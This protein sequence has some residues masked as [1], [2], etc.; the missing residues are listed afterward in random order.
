M[1][2][3]RMLCNSMVAAALGTSCVIALVLLLNPQL[4]L[5]PARL[6]PLVASVGLFYAV[7]L[8][9]IFYLLLVLRQLFAR[10]IFSPAWISV[11]VLVWLSAVAS[12]AGAA[13]M[14]MNLR[15][16]ALVLDATTRR[17]ARPRRHRADRGG[18]AL[19][20]A[21]D[22]PPQRPR[23]ESDV[24]RA[25]RVRG[26]GLGRGAAGAARARHAGSARR[27]LDRRG[28]RRG[29]QRTVGARHDDRDRRRVARSHHARGR[30]RTPAQLRPDSR[31]RRGAPPR[32]GAADLGRGGVGR[33][34]DRQ[35]A[36]EE[37]RPLGRDLSASPAAAG[38]SAAAR[39]LP[40]ARARA[41]FGFLVEEPHTSATLRTRTLWSILST[42]GFSVGVVGWP[43]TQPAAAVRGYLVSD[44]YHRVAR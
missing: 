17:G 20:A 41:R 21:G 1:R 13:L 5:N 11:S 16:F 31:C 10:E 25:A 40:G 14:W 32:D 23:G 43:L 38:D 9:V 36:A 33:G 37:R 22:L 24:G 18:G 34:R 3:L 42:N 6:P 4:P 30:G 19:R 39:L 15:T 35:A 29:A 27:A 12:A 7:H 28:V 26:A 44:T 8:T 2:Y